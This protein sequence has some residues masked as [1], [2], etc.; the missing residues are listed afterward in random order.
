MDRTTR[1]HVALFTVNVIY[2]ANY[3]VAK[4]LMPEVIGPSGFMLLRAMGAAVIFWAIQMV[5]Y[6]PVQAN[7]LIR[8][9]LCAVFGVALNG[10][11][12][13]HGLM[14][15]S[16]LHAGI[17]M[18]ATPILVLVLSGL[19]IGERVTPVKLFGVLLG[20]AGAVLLI[21]QRSSEQAAEASLRGDLYILV[22]ATSYAL[23]LVL[24]KPLLTRYKATTVMA[25][26]F[27]MGFLLILPF[28]W[29]DLGQVEW[30]TMSTFHAGS[31]A[32]V[33]VMVTFVAYSLNTWALRFVNPS[34]VGSYIYLQPVLAMAFALLFVELAR[35][36]PG[37]R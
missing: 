6:E 7:D 20:T 36:W 25:W 22:N 26:V 11:M 24:A 31:M 16:P 23:F 34:V 37:F 5:R 28:G 35:T 19:L 13:L 14:R 4:G 8:L 10:T 21:T 15:T 3:V 33:V 2:G 12:F 17:L 29:K 9:L 27:L 30:R 18:V 32:F 1:A